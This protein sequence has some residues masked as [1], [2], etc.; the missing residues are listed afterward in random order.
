MS[1]WR[2]HFWHAS[3]ATC[4][5]AC[6]F[7]PC[8]LT[9]RLNKCGSR[10]SASLYSCLASC[11]GSVMR[12][13]LLKNEEP[14]RWNVCA[15]QV[16]YFEL[17]FKL[18][19][20]ARPKTSRTTCL[21]FCS[22]RSVLEDSISRSSNGPNRMKNRQPFCTTEVSLCEAFRTL[23]FRSKFNGPN[24]LRRVKNMAYVL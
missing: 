21:K 18:S 5:E 7:G 14:S 19:L 15:H 3:L 9:N 2:L 12:T 24:G 6:V 17:P 23:P 8:T 10:P 11:D 22:E 1:L 20:S 4:I 13:L 16:R